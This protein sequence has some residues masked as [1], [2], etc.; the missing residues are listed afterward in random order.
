MGQSFL[1]NSIWLIELLLKL[2]VCRAT[3]ASGEGVGMPCG[4]AK[5]WR[6][7]SRS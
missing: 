4:F 5:Y 2:P 7:Q 1:L 6:N 3:S